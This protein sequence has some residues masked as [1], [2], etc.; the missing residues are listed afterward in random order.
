MD[1]VTLKA[2]YGVISG[3]ILYFLTFFFTAFLPAFKDLV[4][5]VAYISLYVGYIPLMNI[6][7]IQH[8]KHLTKGIAVYYSIS[9][10]T[11][12]IIY[13]IVPIR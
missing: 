6:L 10:L 5:I 9:F 2:I 13:D 1:I 3:V 4:L 7:N 12:V 8:K 11:W